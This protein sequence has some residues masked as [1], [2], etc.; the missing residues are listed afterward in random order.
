MPTYRLLIGVP[1]RSNAFAIS[2]RLGL[3]QAI[4]D[5]AEGLVSSENK[6]FE[7]VVDSLEM[8]RQRFEHA[9]NELSSQNQEIRK[10]RQELER[11]K[12]QL[13][14]DVE[15]EIQ[16]AREQARRIVDDVRATSQQ[17]LDELEELRKQKER[18]E[19]AAKTYQAK[20][21]VKG[22]LT[23][24]YDMANPVTERKNNG[25]VLPRPLKKGDSV[26]I[27][28]IDKKGVVLQDP[29]A[30]GNVFVQAGIIKTRV[31][32]SNLRLLEEKPVQFQGKTT[33]NIRSKAERSA[34][35]EVD[36]RGETVEEALMDL[37]MFIDNAVMTGI[38]QINII[39]GKGTGALRAAVQQHLKRHPSVR[40]YR[41]GVYGEGETG[42][43]IAELK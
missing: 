14:K 17:M 33:R 25:Y 34:T 5:E 9:E 27:F 20:T 30:S 42:V 19:F 40:T 43:T 23:K 15:R 4:I 10:L 2:K 21:G 37:D 26:L 18:K 38:H 24:L 8:S 7:E 32:V 22:K 29:D 11:Q 6:R 36:L 39:H 12:K 28:D 16:R 31:P 41:L 13:E 1:G 3:S 35:S